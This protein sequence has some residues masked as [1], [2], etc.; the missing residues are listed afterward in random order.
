[1]DPGRDWSGVVDGDLAFFS[2]PENGRATHVGI[3]AM[4][5]RLLHAST[6]RHGVGWD[7]LDPFA[8]SHDENGARLATMLSGVRRLPLAPLDSAR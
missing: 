1:V 8:E 2:E 5:G 7:A 3:L 4:G 6:W